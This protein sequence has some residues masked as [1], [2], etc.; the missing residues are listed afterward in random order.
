[1]DSSRMIYVFFQVGGMWGV[2]VV[3]LLQSI[4]LYII[5]FFFVCLRFD[6]SMTIHNYTKD[7][8]FYPHLGKESSTHRRVLGIEEGRG[9]FECLSS[10]AVTVYQKCQ[11][12]S[13][14]RYCRWLTV[15]GGGKSVLWVTL[16]LLM[17]ERGGALY[18]ANATF[19]SNL[20]HY[21]N[22]SPPKSTNTT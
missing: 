14:C 18:S 16:N 17:C 4:L 2:G 3:S 6:I 22:L 10:Q 20:C 5:G 19:Y 1:M 9:Q 21:I 13:V 15:K 8:S 11:N 7:L 12:E